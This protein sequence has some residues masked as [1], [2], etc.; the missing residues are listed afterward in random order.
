MT[1]RSHSRQR[2]KDKKARA[3]AIAKS[4]AARGLAPRT[5]DNSGS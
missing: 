2:A 3:T 5:D 1:A 4:R